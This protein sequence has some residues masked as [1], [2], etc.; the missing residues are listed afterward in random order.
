MGSCPQCGRPVDDSFHFCPSCGASRTDA[1]VAPRTPSTTS[2]PVQA[3]AP[4]ATAWAPPREGP[5]GPTGRVQ[6]PGLVVLLSIVTVGFYAL[7][8]WWRASKEVDAYWNR[9]NHAH[10]KVKLGLLLLAPVIVFSIFIY[11]TMIADHLGMDTSDGAELGM[12]GSAAAMMLFMTIGLGLWI[13]GGILLLIG[14]WRVWKA[15]QEDERR[16]GVASP[17][18]PGLMLVFMIIPYVS[19][20]TMWI[21]HYRTQKSLNGMWTGG[22]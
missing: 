1:P 15:I 9:P 5:T 16:R 17:L 13:A 7:I 18:S 10:G 8:F 19:F 4:Q 12:G 22:A 20:I 3:P 6:S 11:G 14:L 2:T 21:A